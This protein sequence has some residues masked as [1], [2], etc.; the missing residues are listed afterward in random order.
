[1]VGSAVSFRLTLPAAATY[2]GTAP[3][4]DGDCQATE[5]LTIQEVA[6][7]IEHANLPI[8]YE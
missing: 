5:G 2:Y 4:A 8:Q 3:V 7:L 1:M 6:R